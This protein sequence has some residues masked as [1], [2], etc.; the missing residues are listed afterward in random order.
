MMHLSPPMEK[1]A[2]EEIGN[3]KTEAPKNIREENNEFFPFLMGKR[4]PRR[5]TSMN[6]TAGL[7]KML[8]H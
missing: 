1:E 8:S 2:P 6:H 4:F 5:S 7:K 3:R